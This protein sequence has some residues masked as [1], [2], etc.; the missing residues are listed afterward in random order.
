MNILLLIIVIFIVIKVLG[1]LFDIISE[2]M[3]VIRFFAGLFLKFLKLCIILGI[4]EYVFDSELFEILESSAGKPI[5][6]LTAIDIIWSI[7]SWISSRL[8]TPRLPLI[9]TLIVMLYQRKC[10]KKTYFCEKCQRNLYHKEILR[11]CSDSKCGKA[12]EIKFMDITGKVY[13]KCINNYVSKCEE[14]FNVF[15]TYKGYRDNKIDLICKTCDT[16]LSGG[17]VA[18]FSLYSSDEQLAKDYIVDFFY[19]TFCAGKKTVNMSVETTDKKRLDDIDNEFMHFAP[20]ANTG[21]I[22]DTISLRLQTNNSTVKNTRFQFHTA[23]CSDEARKLKSSEGIIILLDGKNSNYERDSVIDRFL[24]DLQMQNIRGNVW[25]NPV[26]IGV[27]ANGCEFLESEID[28]NASSIAQN[29][30]LCRQFLVN[31]NNED[32]INKLSN[33]IKNVHY[34]VYRTGYKSNGTEEK[35]Y[36][37]AESGQSLLIDVCSELNNVL[38]K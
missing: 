10:K 4:I 13:H 8:L 16:E 19:Y 35:I 11:K 22:L 37:V 29:E 23:I 33:A 20:T 12:Q 1:V 36:N 14:R 9:P 3:P 15:D 34:F 32:I 31:Y 2:L 38:I 28:K 21:R 24:V 17:L 30:Q 6:C 7:V 25:E 26:Y 5:A 27:C 18:S